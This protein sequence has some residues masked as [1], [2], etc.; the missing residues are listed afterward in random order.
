MLRND[1]SPA[2]KG[3]DHVGCNHWV[4]P[5][6]PVYPVYPPSMAWGGTGPAGCCEDRICVQQAGETLYA[7]RVHTQ[8]PWESQRCD[9]GDRWGRGLGWRGWNRALATG[10]G[11]SVSY[12]LA[13]QNSDLKRTGILLFCPMQAPF[14][15]YLNMRVS[16]GA[17]L[18][19]GEVSGDSMELRAGDCPQRQK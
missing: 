13:F 17:G 11:H 16:L 1:V 19:G 5:S 18:G 10:P 15:F 8:L 6:M 3:L 12:L 4:E 2:W 14:P 7:L 9:R